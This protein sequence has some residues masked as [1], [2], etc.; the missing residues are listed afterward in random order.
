LYVDAAAI[1]AG[2]AIL[3]AFTVQAQQQ[4][5]TA[6]RVA[7][8]EASSELTLTLGDVV[9]TAR[10]REELVKDVP[11][12]ETVLSGAALDRDDAARR[13]ARSLRADRTGYRYERE[14]GWKGYHR[15]RHE[16]DNARVIVKAEAF[17]GD[18]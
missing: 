16:I 5:P 11:V 2:I 9:V 3:S 14:V 1:A 6:T 10:K 18:A 12:A 17:R 7:E 15:R 13:T 4:T 8:I